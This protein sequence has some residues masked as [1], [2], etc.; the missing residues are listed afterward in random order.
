MAGTAVQTRSWDSER[1]ARLVTVVYTS[2]ASD[3]S[4]PD[5]TLP[6]LFGFILDEIITIPSS[7]D[8]APETTYRVLLES[9][10]GGV[11]FL[12]ESR[13]LTLEERQGAY[14]YNGK[15]PGVANDLT[16]SLVA[17]DGSTAAA[18]GNSNVVTIALWFV[19]R[20]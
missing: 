10:T 17:A 12:G 14:E 9:A 11:L 1:I 13:S 15:T 20:K 6:G 7:G 8:T 19:K 5:V 18:I 3:G 4:V 2:D 16:L